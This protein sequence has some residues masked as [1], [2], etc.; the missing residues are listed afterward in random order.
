MA[1]GHAWRIVVKDEPNP[2][3]GL[4][5]ANAGAPGTTAMASRCGKRGALLG[6]FRRRKPV[7]RHFNYF[8]Q[9]DL[10]LIGVGMDLI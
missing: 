6:L 9:T 1:L 7:H 3:G 4:A 8:G 5:T 2:G 10:V